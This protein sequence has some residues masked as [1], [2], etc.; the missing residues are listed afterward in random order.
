[1]HIDRSCKM[2]ILTLPSFRGALGTGGW[3][4]FASAVLSA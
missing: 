2:K 1:M 3:N 4:R